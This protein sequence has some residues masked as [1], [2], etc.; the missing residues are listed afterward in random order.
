MPIYAQYY[1][2]LTA[3]SLICFALERIAR[4][5]GNRRS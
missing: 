4:G 1:F 5:V 2:W 3:I